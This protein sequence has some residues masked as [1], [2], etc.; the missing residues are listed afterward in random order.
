MAVL[1]PLAFIQ[2]IIGSVTISEQPVE[3]DGTVLIGE[4]PIEVEGTV[5]I[6]EQPV[7]VNGNVAV[8]GTVSVVEPVTVD[9]TVS[10]NQPV[11]V[12]GTVG[13]TGPVSVD[14]A[15]PVTGVVD[16]EGNATPVEV[17]G[18]V[19]AHRTYKRV[20]IVSPPGEDGFSDDVGLDC[21]AFIPIVTDELSLVFTDRSGNQT[22]LGKDTP[23]ST[24]P[25]SF[26]EG[27]VI[28]FGI[29]I[30]GSSSTGGFIAL[31]YERGENA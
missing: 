8:T 26:L 9:G 2:Q 5:K 11:T 19:E 24:F 18:A 4:Q 6:G 15:V 1:N 27:Q 21:D 31:W 13:V 3:V 29:G 17:Q 30:V 10:V 14:G 28:P 25:A 23:N 7:T 12:D 20:R 22:G 16:D